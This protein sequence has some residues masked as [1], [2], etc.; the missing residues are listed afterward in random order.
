MPEGYLY[1]LPRSFYQ[2][3][4]VT[5]D[6]FDPDKAEA[7]GYSPAQFPAIIKLLGLDQYDTAPLVPPSDSEE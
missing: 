2:Q 4:V 1:D 5:N 3:A 7:L 6:K